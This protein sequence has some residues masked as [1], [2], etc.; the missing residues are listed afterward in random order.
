MSLDLTK[1]LQDLRRDEGYKEKPYV[2][3][4]GKVTIG[5]GHNLTDRGLS[6]AA[7]MFIYNEDAK[8]AI[9]DL[10]RNIP[11]WRDLDE[12]RARA[13]VN[14]CFQLGWP[15]LSKFARMLAAL[16]LGEHAV[17]HQE[18]LDSDWARQ[19]GGDSSSFK[20][21]P[22]RIAHMFLTGQDP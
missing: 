14:M 13:L 16:H 8:L 18:C 11:W 6:S 7:I 19:L 15:G 2:D 1:L 9:G 5:I 10:D 21:R 12:V 4:R 20:T 17:V 3:T 22:A